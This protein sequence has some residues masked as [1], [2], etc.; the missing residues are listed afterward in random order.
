VGV[1]SESFPHETAW[2]DLSGQP[3]DE[4]LDR[5]EAA[6]SRQLDDFEKTYFRNSLVNGAIPVCHEGCALRIWLV[7]AG[8][9]IGRLWLDGR[10]EN[11]GLRPLLLRNGSPATFS[12]WY[13]EWLTDALATITR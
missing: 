3:P 13:D 12:A 4:L 8:N 2:N 6:Y 7:V 5:D 11:A 1:L 9:Q 10:A